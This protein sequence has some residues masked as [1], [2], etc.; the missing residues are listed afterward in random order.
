[1]TSALKL[2][3]PDSTVQCTVM[4][5]CSCVEY[6]WI[7]SWL[8][9]F[10]LETAVTGILTVVNFLNDRDCRYNNNNNNNTLSI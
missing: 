4:L 10:T 1:M 2:P 5:I 9:V 7:A 6:E 8:F 3:C